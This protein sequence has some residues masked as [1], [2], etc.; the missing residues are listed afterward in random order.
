MLLRIISKE[1][2]HNILSFRFVATYSLLFSLI[3]LVLFL[4]ANDYRT[5]VQEYGL[6]TNQERTQ[7]RTL[8]K[9]EDLNQQSRQ[10]HE[11]TFSGT[12]PPQDLSILARGLEG[13]LP[14]TVSSWGPL[15]HNSEDRLGKNLL[16][17]VF[18]TPDFVYIIN[19]VMSL[20]ALL[21]VFDSICGEKE[22][23]TLKI[24]LS[25]SVPRD[26]VLAGKWIGGYL[27]VVAPFS[28]AVLGGFT[29]IYITGALTSGGDALIRFALI[30]ALSLLYISTFFTLGLLISTLTHRSSTA[31]LISL[32]VWICWI[33]V[34]PNLAP[35]IARLSV[36]LPSRQ[37]I[38]E[39][40]QA[41]EQ[42]SEILVESMN[43]RGLT[44]TK[45]ERDKDKIR[46]RGKRAQHSLEEFYQRKLKS[47]VSLG[48]N[49]ARL[50]PS[51]CFL[52]ACT[53]LA[54]T[55]PRLS[56][57]FHQAQERFHSSHQQYRD[58]LEGKWITIKTAGK[59]DWEYEY[60]KRFDAHDLPRFHL[61]QENMG[62][63]FDAAQ[64]DV[65][66]LV[67]YN[68]LFFMLAYLAFL[69]YDVT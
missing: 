19:I 67:I 18:R 47:Q 62:D 42:E 33:L 22:Q 28:V 5:R 11:T 31:L 49:L 61:V 13:S 35:V 32:L 38:D 6:A 10:F 51:A 41:I 40:K 14:T 17:E 25:N 27:S 69:R 45:S 48:Q 7:I 24:L 53:R 65:L 30:F 34:I 58:E 36:P 37:I 1:I 26:L 3:L 63:R 52:F 44:A 9:T 39:E 43:K 23:G 29:Y 15:Y 55:G 20:L 59:L 56:E 66:L 60:K 4:M 46:H 64:F 68:V 57:L 8:E 50:S 21:F 12:R 16:F 54:G 2:V